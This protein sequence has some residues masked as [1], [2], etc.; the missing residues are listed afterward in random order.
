MREKVGKSSTLF[1]AAAAASLRAGG[2]AGIDG[3]R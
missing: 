1:I 3:V 2:R